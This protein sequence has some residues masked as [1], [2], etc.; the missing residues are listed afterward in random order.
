[1]L[2]SRHFVHYSAAFHYSG[3]R[4]FG[5]SLYIFVAGKP[6]HQLFDL[7]CGVSTGA[8]IASLLGFHRFPLDKVENIYNSV[9]TNVF[10]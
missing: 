2:R 3:V 1:M 7:I 4:Y 8:I 10:R 6:I 9:G 5:V